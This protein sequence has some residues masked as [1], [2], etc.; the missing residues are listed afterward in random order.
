MLNQPRPSQRAWGMATTAAYQAAVA[1]LR[2]RNDSKPALKITSAFRT[3]ADSLPEADARRVSL[4]RLANQLEAM[5][6]YSAG[7]R[8]RAITLLKEIAPT[9]P[10][11]ASLPPTVIPSY[12][13]LGEYLLAMGR[14][15]EAAEAF[16][17]VLAF[18]ANRTASVRGLAKARSN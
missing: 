17:K 1:A 4:R 15:Q 2:A 11:N 12:E 16:E 8:E 10:N 3:T 13:L 14:K 9:E 6:A 18:R 7:D 5:T